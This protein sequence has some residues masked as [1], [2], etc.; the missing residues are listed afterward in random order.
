MIKL[1]STARDPYWLDLL[2]GVRVR[3]RPH[4]VVARLTARRA[5][6]A[7]YKEGE[8][9][10]EPETRAGAAYTTGLAS[11]AILD[12]E[13]VGDLDGEA[14]SVTPENI[15]LFLAEPVVWDAFDRLYVMPIV[16]ED[17][18]KNESAPSPNGSSAAAEPTA[19]PADPSAV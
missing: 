13:G 1:G 18:E 2:P 10:F 9:V 5:A 8:E 14:A 17:A 15:E 7:A 12:W 4:S 3:V 19:E 16:L 11:A 6:A